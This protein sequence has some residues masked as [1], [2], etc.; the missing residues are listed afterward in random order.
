MN[1]A[2]LIGIASFVALALGAPVAMAQANGANGGAGAGAGVTAGAGGG[3]EG[4]GAAHGVGGALIAISPSGVREVQQALNRLGYFAGPVNGDWDRQTA[5][6]M[7]HFQEAHGLEPTGNLNFSSVA[8]LGLWNNLIGNPLGN[9]NKALVANTGAPPARGNEKTKVGGEPLPSQ[10]LT[11]TGGGVAGS[12][13][14]VPGQV[15]TGAMAGG[16]ARAG[17]GVGANGGGAGTNGG[18]GG[19][20]AGAN[21]GAANRP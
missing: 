7:L 6:A 20:A 17:A 1:R 13:T 16:G 21:G 12:N 3:A 18:A 5:D 14:Q 4:A 8:G 15:G 2:F 11:T 9:G 10:R 19:G